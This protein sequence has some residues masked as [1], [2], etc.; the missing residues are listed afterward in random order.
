M[1]RKR[2]FL[3]GS[4]SYYVGVGFSD[5]LRNFFSKRGN[6]KLAELAAWMEGRR[7]L[8]GFLEP[9]TATNPAT[10]LIVDREGDYRRAP[11]KDAEEGAAFCRQLGVPVYDAQVL[12]Y[13]DRMKGRPRR[14][15]AD[16][17]G[18]VDAAFAEIEKHLREDG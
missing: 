1:C 6:P 16:I 12:G 17:R 14:E 5:R 2:G 15:E 7:G 18:D 8:E 13:P 4:P 10:L 9:Q 3:C 11:I